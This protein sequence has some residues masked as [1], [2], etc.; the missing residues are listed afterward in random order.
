MTPVACLIPNHHS[1]RRYD[2]NEMNKQFKSDPETRPKTQIPAFKI[3]SKNFKKHLR[4]K[5][6]DDQSKF[7]I[8]FCPLKLLIMLNID[9]T[10]TAYPSVPRSIRATSND[11]EENL[12]NIRT[13]L[14]KNMFFAHC[15]DA[16]LEH[17][18]KGIYTPNW[19]INDEINEGYGDKNIIDYLF[20]K[21]RES[22]NILNRLNYNW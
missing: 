18:Y 13:K 1:R 14:R 3:N 19:D 9:R 5:S 10:F 20:D 22:N 17:Q 2:R 12:N 6:N 15:F 4:I 11:K 7:K 16:T 8:L 21:G